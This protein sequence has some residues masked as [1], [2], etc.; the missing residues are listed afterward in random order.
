MVPETSSGSAVLLPG[1]VTLGVWGIFEADG[2]EGVHSRLGLQATGQSGLRENLL[3]WGRGA[4]M[5]CLS[6][7]ELKLPLLPG[8]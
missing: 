7:V 1:L 4:G 3:Y 6:S 5:G 8:L 2:V